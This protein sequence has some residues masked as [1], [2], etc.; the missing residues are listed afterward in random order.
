MNFTSIFSTTVSYPLV[1][2]LICLGIS[3][4]LGLL[5]AVAYML[6]GP[7]TKSFAISLVLIPAVVETVILFV[8]QNFGAAL[9]VGGTFALLRFRSA[10]G[11]AREI[12]ALFC[13]VAVGITAGMGFVLYAI[14]VTVIFA[15]VIVLLGITPFGEDGGNDRTLKILIPES[16]DYTGVFDDI[17]GEYTRK[18]NLELVRTTNMGSLYELRYVITL[19]DKKKEKDMI[20]RLRERNG[21]LPITSAT[22]M[23]KKDEL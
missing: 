20:D 4:L 13:A 7:Y 3:L 1:E 6:S 18:F 2:T 12:T 19:K 22:V 15:L 11:T 9:A 17:L 14:I 21:N 23:P 8:N 10:P 16:L 5:L